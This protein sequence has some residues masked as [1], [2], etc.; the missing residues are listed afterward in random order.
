MANGVLCHVIITSHAADKKAASF[1]SDSLAFSTHT[2]FALLAK[3]SSQS[4]IPSNSDWWLD[5][6][7]LFYQRNPD[8]F[9]CKLALFFK[10]NIELCFNFLR[11][12]RL[13]LAEHHEKENL[14][15][16]NIFIRGR[17][18]NQTGKSY[19]GVTPFGPSMWQ[20]EADAELTLSASLGKCAKADFRGLIK[21]DFQEWSKADSTLTTAFVTPKD[22]YDPSIAFR[23]PPLGLG[24]MGSRRQ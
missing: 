15:E 13:E 19:L 20:A 17:A 4:K 12:D 22:Y 24:W 8:S 18:P 6:H 9:A 5:G 23:P 2:A 7:L 21:A 1:F 10:L 11:N 14:L 3:F 16:I